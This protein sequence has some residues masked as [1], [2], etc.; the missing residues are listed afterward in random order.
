MNPA[1]HSVPT[2]SQAGDASLTPSCFGPGRPRHGQRLAAHGKPHVG[3]LSHNLE[4]RWQPLIY[5]SLLGYE[6]LADK[7]QCRSSA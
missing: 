5:L 7:L 2:L 4:E 6:S 3:N 1:H